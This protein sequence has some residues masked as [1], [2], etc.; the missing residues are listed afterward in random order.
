MDKRLEALQRDVK[1]LS[2][3]VDKLMQ[4]RQRQDGYLNDADKERMEDMQRKIAARSGNDEN[5]LMPWTKNNDILYSLLCVAFFADEE[6]DESE[7]DI[8]FDSYKIFVPELNNEMFN[9]DFGLATSKF[10]DLK[11]EELR[12]KQFDQSLDSIRQNLTKDNLN[13][14]VEC[15]VKIANADDFIHENEVALI[16]QAIKKWSLDFKIEKP[17][18]GKKLKLKIKITSQEQRKKLEL[19]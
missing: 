4:K 1:F 11:T 2:L 17:K 7:K 5:D 10:I 14:L 13:Q 12:Q 19:N 8:I 15:Y 18:S 9:N 3:E 16:R 6:I